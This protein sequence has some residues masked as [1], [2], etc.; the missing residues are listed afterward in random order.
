MKALSLTEAS[1]IQPFTY[2][3]IVWSIPIGFVVFGA[4]PIWST[5]LGAIMI[6]G[7][8]SLCDLQRSGANLLTNVKREGF[9]Y[10]E[11]RKRNKCRSQEGAQPPPLLENY[12]YI[13]YC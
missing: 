2:M 6:V 5:I 12:D 11:S 8:R 3:Q 10:N 9:S 1:A 7:G 4:L 13:P